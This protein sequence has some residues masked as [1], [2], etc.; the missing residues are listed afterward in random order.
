MSK[1]SRGTILLL[2]G[3]G[4]VSSRLAP[5][6]TSNGNPVLLA[7]RSGKAPDL[8]HCHGIKFDWFDQSTYINLFTTG[9]TISA[10]FIVA[11]SIMHQ[12][13]LMKTFIDLAI[14]KGVKR[15]VLLSGSVLPVGD[16][17]M[18]GAVSKYIVSL[19]VEYAILRPS[20]FMENFSEVEHFRSI[21]DG[22][23]IVTAAGDGKVPFVSANDIAA[24]AFRALTDEVS[25][26]ADH[27]ILGHGLFSYDEVSH[28]LL[29]SLRETNSIQ[30]C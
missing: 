7:S 20:W 14:S 19:N 22:D 13:P 5:L 1:S 21:I 28:I 10:I 23:K 4:K 30:G 25:H 11:P 3:T 27:L 6:L 12:M 8:P 18:M 9:S 15:F 17:P 29:V 24:V 16:G 26:N 2:G